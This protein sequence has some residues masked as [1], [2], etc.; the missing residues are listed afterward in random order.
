[1]TP[2]LHWPEIALRLL[3]SGLAGG[4]IGINRSERG[5]A[6]G[7]RTTILLCVAA[8]V[9]MVQANVLLNTNGKPPGSFAVADVLRL[10]L[11][12]L[13]GMGFIGAG[14]IVRREDMVLGV[15]TAAT[16]WFVTVMGLCFGGGQIGLGLASLGLGWGTL[17]GLTE[18]ENRLPR[19][20]RATLEISTDERPVEN[21]LRGALCA[22]GFHIASSAVREDTRE[23]LREICWSVEWRGRFSSEIPAVVEDFARRPDV[24]RL[25][26]RP[27]TA[28][29]LAS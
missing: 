1:M 26:W 15:T 13:S 16:L 24:R 4:L 2:N 7:L 10:P 22:A 12:I 29:G 11:G 9:S 14:A 6:A 28:A 27:S 8:A 17:A 23:H 25:T 3:L 21:E 19:D 20:Q 18:L 5:R